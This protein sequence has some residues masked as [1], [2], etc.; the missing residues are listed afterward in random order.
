[1]VYLPPPH[2]AE[3]GRPSYAE[4]YAKILA[5]FRSS[6]LTSASSVLVLVAPDTD[7]VCAARMLSDLFNQDDIIHR[8]RPVSGFDELER[9]RDDLIG[10]TEVVLVQLYL[11]VLIDHSS[12]ATHTHPS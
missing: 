11:H 8:I 1:M 10:Y 9:I 4:A 5:A 3:P 2:L 6:P 7:A 12:T